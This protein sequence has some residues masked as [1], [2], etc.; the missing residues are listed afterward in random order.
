MAIAALGAARYALPLVDEGLREWSLALGL[1][2]LASVAAAYALA[3]RVAQRA[4]C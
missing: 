4:R 1:A 3:L 2:V